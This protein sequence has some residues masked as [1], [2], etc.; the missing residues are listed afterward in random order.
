MKRIVLTANRCLICKTLLTLP[1][2]HVLATDIICKRCYNK[3][4]FIYKKFV[5]DKVKCLAIYEY[6]ETV[7][8]LLL[9][10]KMQGDKELAKVFL[11]PIKHYLKCHYKNF[12]VLPVPSS[13]EADKRRGFNHVTEIVK[14][15][16]LPYVTAFFKN[17]SH[18]QSM[19]K[20]YERVNVKRVIKLNENLL[21]HNNKYLI[22]DDLT[23]THQTIHQCIKLLN[24]F[25]VRKIEVL[26]VAMKRRNLYE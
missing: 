6:N 13:K 3:F 20:K 11:M 25:G 23:T 19:Q 18:K 7:R 1:H 4:K 21:D 2:T 22:V 26:I 9:R 24:G 10:L 12:I 8:S 14:T 15:I 17:S 16:D 5:I